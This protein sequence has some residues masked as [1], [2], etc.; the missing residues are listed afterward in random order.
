MLYKQI[1][2]SARASAEVGYGCITI[3]GEKVIIKQG[4]PRTAAAAVLL[5]VRTR[6]RFLCV[7]FLLPVI[8]P[9]ATKRGVGL[10]LDLGATGST[11]VVGG[12]VLQQ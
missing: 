7:R 12:A 11:A 2:Q 4:Q 6:I 9:L 1:I 5:V 8:L 3:F 10:L